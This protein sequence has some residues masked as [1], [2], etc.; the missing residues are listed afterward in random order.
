MNTQHHDDHHDLTAR[1]SCWLSGE[2]DQAAAGSLDRAVRR[3]PAAQRIA[4]GYRRVDALARDWYDALPVEPERMMAAPPPLAR[5][6]RARGLVA[7]L[8]G[9]L[10]VACSARIDVTAAVTRVFDAASTMIVPEAGAGARGVPNSY[11]HLRAA[12]LG[13]TDAGRRGGEWPTGRPRGS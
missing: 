1:I 9:C 4:A 3:D 8:A 5:P 6:S 12:V 7:A 10:L 2:L 13:W 11:G